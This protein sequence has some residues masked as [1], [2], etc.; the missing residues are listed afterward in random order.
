MA[1]VQAATGINKQINYQGRLLTRGGGVVADGTYN[2]R[3]RV[4]QD[5][6]GVLGGGDEVLKWTEEYKNSSSQGVVVKNGY[7]SVALA[8]YCPLD[9]SAC[10][11]Q[12][13]T[14]SAIDFNQ[15]ALWLSMDVGGTGSG[16][17]TYDGELTPF[18]RLTSAV[19]AFQSA[20]ANKLNGLTSGQFVQLAPAAVQ[21][22]S[23]TNA[24]IF[25]NKTAAGNLMTLQKGGVDAF[26]VDNT[27]NLLFGNNADKTVQIAQAA[28]STAGN[29]LTVAAGQGGT[30]T[31]SVGGKLV[32]QGGAA[33]GT[34]ANGGDVLVYGGAKTAAGTNGNVSLAFDG[35]SA[36]GTVGIGKAASSS[37][38]LDVN[39]AINSSGTISA[40][41]SVTAPQFSSSGAVTV[42]SGGSGDLTL[43]TASGT[44]VTNA[45]T[46]Q[47]TAAG[48]TNLDLKDGSNTT[49]AITNSGV[50]VANLSLDGAATLQ[51]ANALTLGT[52]G[53][54]TGAIVFKGATAASGTLTLRGPNNPTTATL[55]IPAISGPANVCTDNAICAGYTG[56]P[57]SGSYIR[58]IPTTT[59]Q[60]T[61]SPATASIAALTVTGTSSTAAQALIVNQAGGADAV[62]VNVTG[63]S[64]T[65]G[66]SITRTNAGTLT[67]ALAITNT[68]GTVTNGL[69]FSGTIG[70]DIFRGA[71]SALTIQGTS[72]V[73]LT[74]AGTAALTLDTGTSG[75]GATVS[76]GN[77]N[78]TTINIGSSAP[79]GVRNTTIAGG[80]STVV[81]TVNIATGATTVAGGKTVHI[82]DGTPTG[83][84]TNLV[85]IGSLA[86]DSTTT[87]Q[88]GS[89][90]ILLTTNQ[91]SAS[92]IVKTQTINS[93][94][95]FQIQNA[96]GTNFFTADSTNKILTS[97]DL[98]VGA[99]AGGGTRLFSDS[100][101]GGTYGLWDLGSTIAGT[102]TATIDST[103][104]RNGKYA[105]KFTVGTGNDYYVARIKPQT[106]NV[107]MRAYVYLATN[108]TTAN[109]IN[110]MDMTNGALG[111]FS[112]AFIKS[113]S[114][115]GLW[116]G[117]A[118]TTHDTGATF[119]LNTWHMLE[120]RGSGTGGAALQAWLDGSLVG[121]YTTSNNITLSEIHIGEDNTA[122]N[123]VFYVDDVSADTGITSTTDG[124]SMYVGDSLHVGGSSTL[125]QVEMI[126]GT[127]T[128]Q[129]FSVHDAS[130]NTLLAVDT[131]NFGVT[132]LG[133]P[134]RDVGAWKTNATAITPSARSASASVT[135][136]G[137]VYL[138]GGGTGADGSGTVNTVLY[139]KLNA[140]G[141]VGA[142]T[143][144]ANN[145]AT[146]VAQ[147]GAAVVNGYVY[148]VG[149]ET[150]G[151]NSGTVTATVQY[152]KL[153]ADGSTGAWK[154][155]TS[156]QTGVADCGVTTY[157]GYLYCVAGFTSAGTPQA[158][159]QYIKVNSDGSLPSAWTNT[160]PGGDIPNTAVGRNA[161]VMNG[162]M[163]KFSGGST[164]GQVAYG[165]INPSTGVVSW[166]SNPVTLPGSI[167][168]P[169]LS[170]V[171]MNGYVYIYGGFLGSP[172]NDATTQVYYAKQSSNGQLGSW[173]ASANSLPV[174]REYLG[175]VA[176]NGY[177]YAIGGDD[178]TSGATTVYYTSTSRVQVGAN[179]DLVG[180]QNQTLADPG[181]GSVGSLGGS[182]TA[183]SGTFVGALSVQGQGT[184]VN[185]VTVSGPFAAYG[186]LT[187]GGGF[188]TTDTTEN[189][190]QLDST[191]TFAEAAGTC[192]A[193]VNDGA[194]YYNSA[195][196]GT[197][198][199]GSSAIRA[200]VNGAW[201]DLVS[202]GG[203]GL[204]VFG[205]VPDSGPTA[206]DQIGITGYTNSAC[207]V[208]WASTTS[209]NIANCIAYSGGRKV[210]LSG[211]NALTGFSAANSWYHIC[212]NGTNN[213]PAKTT[214]NGTETANLP[215]F[216]AGS[217]IL[218]IAD[219]KTGGGSTITNIY[220]T[221][222]FVTSSRQ[223]AT[224]NSAATPGMIVRYNSAGTAGTVETT[225]T[226]NSTVVAGVVAAVSG[227]ASANTVN[228]I[229]VTSGLT[230]V[231]ALG[232]ATFANTATTSTTAGYITNGTTA[233]S[234][235]GAI[236]KTADTTC[237]AATDCQFSEGV[238]VSP[239]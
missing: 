182:V 76:L 160:T 106:G 113:N 119:S 44:L 79:A 29:K 184:F 140:D 130:G 189:D 33:G 194:M 54:N 135:A 122:T 28:A 169:N 99:S 229:I 170:A 144:S 82:A 110:F 188:S 39:G 24:S 14:N 91:A 155:T 107:Y 41:T 149:G 96:A 215:T 206:G 57:A 211:L 214:A 185:G 77:T 78:A 17:I 49:L 75:V 95:A 201:E 202:T 222:T 18:K 183:G 71:G 2:V 108:T 15:S 191:T 42:Q 199:G 209:V 69:V 133:S 56:T 16:A 145:L 218:C 205:V 43:T 52:T 236:L 53:T 197:T 88:G 195:Q 221:R 12:S 228:G 154:A 85:T 26:D 208:R 203:L 196:T 97:A 233:N 30:G 118:S 50:G 204:M 152:A 104:K 177:I 178:N 239:H 9:G 89:G 148:V 181:D 109:N 64:Q 210:V 22:D 19:Y 94:T 72:G 173:T 186:G 137:Y 126:P 37:F 150:T 20:D 143:T 164:P 8:T 193:T 63:G 132:F 207:K 36:V 217:P 180:L 58:T 163:Y 5:G 226:A 235:L 73:T 179:L 102:S 6:D 227:T 7:F 172:T 100:F 129:A 117:G 174:K 232:T 136:N 175:A 3:F 123:A 65:N 139:A 120:L 27:G 62:N 70:A 234:M 87:I 158:Y 166:A 31:G 67:N 146:G 134:S 161:V 219:V 32:L 168:W 13:Q 86:N 165:A 111:D 11:G 190:M 213:A 116:D 127:D 159:T 66:L 80:N 34:N 153:N 59:P 21:V 35:T 23:T 48:T 128:T 25:L 198:Q 212:L 112:L 55:N 61:I 40:T 171:A 98:N 84:G 121:T 176:V 147:A 200:C 141:S 167:D 124:G 125:G 68:S 10:T 83:S 60:N 237:T 51:G 114:H 93:T 4:Y 105:A 131:S 231:K 101:E 45:S 142:W 223:F 238:D 103:T 81:D 138:L 151:G 192:S 46:I 225:A 220:D 74:A 230:M 90:N 38:A 216:S 224:I 47:R 1:P 157:N 92:T 187:V 156:L 115:L 162:Y